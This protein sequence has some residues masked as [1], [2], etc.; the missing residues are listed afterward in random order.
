[1]RKQLLALAA[2]CCL[3]AQASADVAVIVHPSNAAGMDGKA[4]E[5]LFLSKAK[6]FPGGGEAVPINQ[7]EGSSARSEFDKK[8]L[9]KTSAQLTAY[10]SKLVFTGK[11]TPP[12]DVASDAEVMSLIAANPNMIGYVDAGAVDGSVKVVQTF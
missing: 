12:K 1:M 6:S 7:S 3:T 9:G 11:G 5:K 2:A 8:V 4:I 10:W